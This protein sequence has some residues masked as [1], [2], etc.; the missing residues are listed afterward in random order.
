MQA[1][2]CDARWSFWILAE[3]IGC[4]LRPSR[5]SCW[6]NKCVLKPVCMNGS[7][8]LLWLIAA[9]KKDFSLRWNETCFFCACISSLCIWCAWLCQELNK[10]SLQDVLVSCYRCHAMLSRVIVSLKSVVNKKN[11]TYSMQCTSFSGTCFLKDYLPPF[12][13]MLFLPL[14]HSSL[15]LETAVQSSHE[16]SL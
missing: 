8:W 16:L 12:S 3:Q 1:S 15:L 7:E 14:S 13:G 4:G 2:C 6:V 11:W 5:F 9:L 10:D